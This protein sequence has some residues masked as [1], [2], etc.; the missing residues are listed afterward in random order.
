[1][2]LLGFS[3]STIE[4]YV[5]YKKW[6]FGLKIMKFEIWD[7]S[8]WISGLEISKCGQNIS[9][10]GF[11]QIIYHYNPHDELRNN[12]IRWNCISESLNVDRVCSILVIISVI[13]LYFGIFQRIYFWIAKVFKRGLKLPYSWVSH[14]ALSNGMWFIKSNFFGWN[15]R[16]LKFEFLS[17][18]VSGGD[19]KI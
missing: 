19:L 18:R 11:R 17:F 10:L 3:S 5:I 1:M 4:W 2:I 6:F 8:F 15:F 7:L 16:N 14:Q 13:S 12:I 9:V